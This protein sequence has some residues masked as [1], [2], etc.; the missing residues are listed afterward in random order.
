M[1]N[2]SW[3]SISVTSSSA[4]IQ[5]VL[6]GSNTTVTQNTVTPASSYPLPVTLLDSSGVRTNF[7]TSSNQTNGNQ[8]TQI[9]DGSGNVIAS[10]NN[11]LNVNL[12]N[13]F[14]S[15]A[16]S[17]ATP[18]G[19]SASFT[20]TPAD[21]TNYSSVNILVSTDRSG[22]LNMQFSS[23]GTNW[24][25]DD[26]YACT[27]TTGGVNQSFYFQGAPVAKYF[28]VKYENGATAQGVFRL[29]TVFK[30]N[31]GVGDVQDLSTVP[32]DGSN[33][34]ITK[35]V[36]YGKTT[37]GGGGFVAV[38]VNPSG[39]LTTDVSG[40]VAATQS[41]TWNITNVS[42]TV[43]LPT[44]AS[45]L[46]EQQTQSTTLSTI[47]GKLPTTLGQKAM[48]ASL[49]VTLASDQSAV[50]ATQ[51]G[52][53]NINNISGTV[54]LPTGAA[55]ETTLSALNTKVT[56]CNTGAVTIATALPAG[57]NTIGYI[58][59]S[60]LAKSNT[61]VYNSY[62]STNVTTSAYVQLIASITSEV[63]LVSIFDSSGQA[64]IIATGGAG[65]E[66]DQLYVPPGGGDFP[67]LIAAGTRL[68]IKALTATA[69]S[70]YLL[71]NLLG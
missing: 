50:P 12:I 67:L 24:D 17:S 34:L 71:V 43:S 29:Q 26:A 4:P 16:N 47:S 22:T 11:S 15:T 51:S 36:I 57:T 2:F 59:Q 3:P 44:G 65:S 7:A 9:V 10:T 33:G 62:S 70:G 61:P 1:A 69:S 46:A 28:R 49:A 60:G 5:Y 66:V 68:S 35:S 30:V 14:L 64:M 6:D 19:I 55:T 38:K 56:A 13:G 27:V 32:I 21:I 8:K 42:G 45:T 31:S 48:A 58:K 37:G 25:H 41:G 20:G 53:W 23:D 39:A 18:L 63:D 52:T 54:S 40:T